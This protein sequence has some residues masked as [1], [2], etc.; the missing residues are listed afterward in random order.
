[1]PFSISVVHCVG[2]P[3]S[4]MLSEPRRPVQRAVVD[5][6]AQPFEATRWP[7]RPA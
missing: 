7:M 2:V 4:S 6:G 5:D 3:S 1:M